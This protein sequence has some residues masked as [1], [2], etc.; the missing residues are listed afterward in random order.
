[1]KRVFTYNIGLK[2]VSLVLA[3]LTWF[4]IDAE[5]MKSRD[6]ISMPTFKEEPVEELKVDRIDFIK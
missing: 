4:Y 2:L 3:I 1:M 5:L 6:V